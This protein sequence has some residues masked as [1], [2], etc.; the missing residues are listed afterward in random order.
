M[1]FLN[2]LITWLFFAVFGFM[3]LGHII[4]E[5]VSNYF[6]SWSSTNWYRDRLLLKIEA[7]EASLTN[8]GST[9]QD[10]KL[11]PRCRLRTD[12]MQGQKILKQ[13][14]RQLMSRYGVNRRSCICSEIVKPSPGQTTYAAA[15]TTWSAPLE[16]FRKSDKD[17]PLRTEITSRTVELILLLSPKAVALWALR[18]LRRACVGFVAG[19]SHARNNTH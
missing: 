17:G 11:R 8:A 18:A 10:A 6:T 14:F 7:D 5:L 2:L 9:R 16:H 1:F 19:R 12:E 3:P 4:N 13:L 15:T